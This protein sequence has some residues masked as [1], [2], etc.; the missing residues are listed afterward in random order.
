MLE[1]NATE[2]LKLANDRNV[3]AFKQRGVINTNCLWK[4]LIASHVRFQVLTAARIKI[5]A[6]WDIAPCLHGYT[7]LYP[8][9]Q[10]P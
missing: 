9:K 6:F 1:R 3:H 2:E 7:A 10:S 5:T 8:R 4:E